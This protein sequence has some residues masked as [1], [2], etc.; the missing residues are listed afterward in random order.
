MEKTLNCCGFSSF[1]SNSTCAAV[2]KF[3][4]F[5][6]PPKLVQSRLLCPSLFAR[7]TPSCVEPLIDPCVDF[8][9]ASVFS[10]SPAFAARRCRLVTRVPASCRNTRARFC[11]LWVASDSSSVSQR[12]VK[13]CRFRFLQMWDFKGLVLPADLWSVAGP[14]VQEHQGPSIQS[15]SLSLAV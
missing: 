6:R 1:D 12:S 10:F 7:F 2:S 3:G 14:Q 8:Y 5:F 4:G 11:G 13:G 9:D 15:R